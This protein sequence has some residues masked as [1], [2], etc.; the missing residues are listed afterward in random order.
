[1][2]AFAAAPSPV[3]LATAAFLPSSPRPVSPP[4]SSTRC[5]AGDLDL[6]ATPSRPYLL[7]LLTPSRRSRT[8]DELPAAAPDPALGDVPSILLPAATL[9]QIPLGIHRANQ[10]PPILFLG[11]ISSRSTSGSPS[12]RS[13]THQQDPE[14]PIHPSPSLRAAAA[15]PCASPASSSSSRARGNR[16][17]CSER[18]GHLLPRAPARIQ[19]ARSI[20]IGSS[21]H[22]RAREE[23]ARGFRDHDLDS[24]PPLCSPSFAE[25]PASFPTPTLAFA[26]APSPVRL[27]TAAFLPSSLRPVS[28]P[29]S[30][31]HCPAGDLDLQAT[32]SRPCL[33][34]L[35]TPSRRSRTG[36][37]LP[38]AA[39][40]P[41]LVSSPGRPPRPH[42]PRRRRSSKPRRCVLCF[43]LLLPVPLLDLLEPPLLC[44]LSSRGARSP[45]RLP[46]GGCPDGPHRLPLAPP[47]VAS[48]PDPAQWPML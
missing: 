30:S 24:R 48:S 46:V 38:A 18:L 32:P 15:S 23:L 39:P 41:A 28:P 45:A 13:S 21:L 47:W 43:V 6:Q 3:R 34:D 5:P 9:Y 16:L 36:D 7:D 11:S 8:G 40:D 10:P 4:F 42:L 22:P 31:T 20:R 33:L 27:A 12:P 17:L 35:L 44:F 25:P 26:A 29:F 37:E 19:P 1:M 2:P 14:H